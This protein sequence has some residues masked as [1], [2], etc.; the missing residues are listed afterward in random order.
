MYGRSD[1]RKSRIYLIFIGLLVASGV[2]AGEERS[3]SSQLDPKD[4]F[5]RQTVYAIGPS[6]ERCA[7]IKS[8]AP[9]N[10]WGNRER[11][12]QTETVSQDG[13]VLA[14]IGRHE[15]GTETI[16][17]FFSRQNECLAFTRKPTPRPT[18]S[19]SLS[20]AEAEK[21]R[22]KPSCFEVLVNG[23]IASSPGDVEALHAPHL[24]ASQLEDVLARHP[25]SCRINQFGV[26]YGCQGG[27]YISGR[28]A[29]VM[30]W[31]PNHY[32]IEMPLDFER[33]RKDAPA[34]VRRSEARCLRSSAQ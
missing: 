32:I 17:R 7:P 31:T 8:G 29:R 5:F 16:Y 21:Q 13:R 25:Y 10:L 30:N 15:D 9:A 34:V 11:V 2:H 24:S 33:G 3:G 26:A 4:A 1:N 23:L 14:I 19:G 18:S 12:E 22:T 6:M 20:Q 27:A 28:K